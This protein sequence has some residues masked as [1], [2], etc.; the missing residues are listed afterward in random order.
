MRLRGDL[1]TSAGAVTAAPLAIAMLDAAVVN[2][3]SVHVR[4]VTQVDITI[5]DCAIDVDRVLLDGAITAEARSHLFT[6]ARIRDADDSGRQ[7]GFG[8]A[9]W[10]VVG[11]DAAAV[12]L[13]RARCHQFPDWRDSAVMAGIF[14]SSTVRWAAR[15]P[16][17]AGSRRRASA[18]CTH[19][20]RDRSGGVGVRGTG[21]GHRCAVG[22]L[23]Q[24]DD[25]RPRASRT[26]RRHAGVQCGRYRYRRLPGGT[27]GRRTRKLLGGRRFP[28]HAGV[29]D[30]DAGLNLKAWT[31]RR[32]PSRSR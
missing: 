14:G 28:P 9:N 7:I 31:I 12:L 18:P 3:E 8:S 19:A 4:A 16:A 27:S 11:S 26:I 29:L 1:R 20:G 2:V 25:G 24:H 6:E 13:S 15:D 23:P 32:T 30:V 17:P 21:A 22:R 5:V 10:A